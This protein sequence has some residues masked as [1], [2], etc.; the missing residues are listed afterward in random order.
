MRSL[1]DDIIK[2]KQDVMVASGICPDTI[3]MSSTIY[4]CLRE[5]MHKLDKYTPLM[6]VSTI[7][8]MTI[9]ICDT[10]E[11]IIIE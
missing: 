5:E 3:R 8:G 9:V 2:A 7:L 1:I 11:R 6:N 4:R 10:D